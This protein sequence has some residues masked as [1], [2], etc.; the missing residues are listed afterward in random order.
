MCQVQRFGPAMANAVKEA[1]AAGHGGAI[2]V[3][4]F[5]GK[6]SASGFSCCQTTIAS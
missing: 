2:R 6:L 4:L 5:A 3:A 1:S